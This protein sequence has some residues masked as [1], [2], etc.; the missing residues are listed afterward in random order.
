MKTFINKVKENKAT[1]LKLLCLLLVVALISLITLGVLLLTGVLNYDDGFVF[2]EHI[3]DA[4]KGKWYGFIVFILVQTLLSMLLCVIPGVAAAFVMFSTVLY[5]NPWMAFLLSYS[6]VVIASTVLYIVGRMGGYKLCEKLLGKEDCEKSLNLLRTRGTVYFPLMMLFPIFPD[7]ALVMIA[8]VTKMKLSWFIPSILICR[9]V[10][11]ATIIFGMSVIPF[12]SF[13]SAYDWLI[14]LTV[15]FFWIKQIFTLANKVDRYFERKRNPEKNDRAFSPA[16]PKNYLKFYRSLVTVI[17]SLG[18]SFISFGFITE[19]YEWMVIITVC[20][21][22]V[23]EIFLIADKLH[24]DIMY[25]KKVKEAIVSGTP[26][27]PRAGSVNTFHSIATAILCTAIT[28]I[29]FAIFN[30]VMKL[31]VLV[32]ISFFWIREIFKIA[33][34]VDGHFTM[35][36]N[37]RNALIQAEIAKARETST[38]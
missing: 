8:G 13:T 4:F 33:N 11:A 2:N 36:R 26:I 7:D 27:Q 12:D 23:R 9:G 5:P 10:G 3:L 20:F 6:C 14:L 34:K 18:I 31:L 25:N 35:K 32:T 21:F 17:V 29:H 19:I 16:S 15:G 28:I 1:I 38:K 37:E 24:D 22:W 30:N